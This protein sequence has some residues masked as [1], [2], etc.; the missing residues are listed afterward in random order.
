MFKILERAYVWFS[1]FPYFKMVICIDLHS[2]LEETCA[3]EC[4]FSIALLIYMYS[5]GN[6][7]QFTTEFTIK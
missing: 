4:A 5:N 6:S 2:S 3:I 1:R 7:L